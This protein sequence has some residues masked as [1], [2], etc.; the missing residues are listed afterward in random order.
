MTD[1]LAG[2]VLDALRER[3]SGVYL[4]SAA[5]GLFLRSHASAIERYAEAKSRGSRG[6]AALGEIEE[7]ARGLFAGLLGAAAGDI[8]FVAS[9]SRG[10]DAAIKSIEWDPG[11]SIVLGD[12]EFPSAFF[13]AALLQREG[14]TTTLVPYRD[15]AVHES[16]IAAAIDDSTR[17]VVVSLVS[18]KTGQRM[19]IGAIAAAAHAHGALVFVD[20]VQA[21]GAVTVAP[22]GADFLCAATF[23]WMLGA[24]GLAALYVAPRVAQHS[25][26][27]Y[28]GYRSVSELFPPD[29][30]HFELYEDARRYEEGMPNLLGISVLESAL[31]HMNEIGIAEIEHHNQA[32]VGRLRDGLHH[33]SV[34]VL[35][36]DDVTTRG[37][38]VSFESARETEIASYLDSLDTTVWA[39]DGRVRLA[40]HA[41]NTQADIDTALE[42]LAAFPG[43]L[44]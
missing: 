11:D 3:P 44:S 7:R 23:K 10:L 18:Y 27:P 36:P 12:A 16:D 2:R 21:V 9:T 13:S 20:A 29:V 30:R 41:Y 6:R 37:S 28:A 1:E 19:D 38:I 42:Q 22:D 24:H 40:P 17:L 8:A 39:R 15:G 26:P 32:L 25:R 35:C 5:E 4:N 33:L 31:T 34:P 43:G 14:V